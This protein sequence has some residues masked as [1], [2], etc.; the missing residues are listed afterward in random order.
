MKDIKK[1]HILS[2]NFSVPEKIWNL[3]TTYLELLFISTAV[4]FNNESLTYQ[5]WF[6]LDVPF[7]ILKL[8]ARSSKEDFLKEKKIG[9]LWITRR[10]CASKIQ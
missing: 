4:H 2:Y 1:Q 10:I 8:W 7:F 6:V 5:T 9:I 3:W